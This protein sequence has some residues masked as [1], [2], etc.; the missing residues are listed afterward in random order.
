MYGAPQKVMD[1]GRDHR[2]IH[3]AKSKK[4]LFSEFSAF[5]GSE[6]SVPTSTTDT[7][8]IDFCSSVF[9]DLID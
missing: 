2:I 7:V 3:S 8:D 4:K 1:E 5:G 9:A 6:T